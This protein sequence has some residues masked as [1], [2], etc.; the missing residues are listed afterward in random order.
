MKQGMLWYDSGS[1][2]DIN[3]RIENAVSYFVQ[4]YG[5]KPETCFVNPEMLSGS[6]GM[7]LSIKVVSDEKILRNHIW[8]EFPRIE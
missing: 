3:E 2:K 6:N 1:S 7:A 5:H 4:K 8:I